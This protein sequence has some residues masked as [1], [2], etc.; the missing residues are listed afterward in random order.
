[1]KSKFR[2]RAAAESAELSIHDEIGAC[3]ISA[4]EFIAEIGKLP[5]DAALTLRLN[6]PG[7]SVFDAVAIHNT[8]KRHEGTVSVWIDEI[9]ARPPPTSPWRATRPSCWK[10][11][12]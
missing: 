8:L 3:G 6:S 11:P 10:A 4:K 2:F 1:M 7:G 5:G 12:S 9:A